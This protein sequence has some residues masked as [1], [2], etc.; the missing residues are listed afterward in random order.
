M[1]LAKHF[2]NQALVAI[3]D[4]AQEKAEVDDLKSLGIG[5]S[6]RGASKT[7]PTSVTQ[8]QPVS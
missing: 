3:L 7:S 4:V 8:P 1:D 6:H 2:D 5:T